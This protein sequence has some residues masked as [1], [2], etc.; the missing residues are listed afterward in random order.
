MFRRAEGAPIDIR[1]H[2][3]RRWFARVPR[4]SSYRLAGP[5]WPACQWQ[6]LDAW[7]QRGPQVCI[8]DNRRLIGVN[9]RFD[10]SWCVNF[11]QSN[12]G[13]C[14]SIAGFNRSLSQ[15]I[16]GYRR[17]SQA[18]FFLDFW[19]AMASL[20]FGLATPPPPT[21]PSGNS[22]QAQPKWGAHI[23]LVLFCFFHRATMYLASRPVGSSYVCT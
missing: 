19:V 18:I 3:R 10:R 8:A 9:C 1:I 5:G 11:P 16:A 6:P 7:C 20:Y 17:L 22:R 2:R 13:A 12:F 15:A 21:A 4:A 14:W 23:P